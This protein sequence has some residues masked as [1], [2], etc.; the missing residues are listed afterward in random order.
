MSKPVSVEAFAEKKVSRGT[1][2]QLEFKV[3][4]PVMLGDMFHVKP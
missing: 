4:K 2:M 3:A 1:Q